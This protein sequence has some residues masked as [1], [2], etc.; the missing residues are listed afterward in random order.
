MLPLQ[1]HALE[2]LSLRT[3]PRTTAAATGAGTDDGPKAGQ[4]DLQVLLDG[5]RQG[6]EDA[7]SVSAPPVSHLPGST[8]LQ[9]LLLRLRLGSRDSRTA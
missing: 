7:G 5:E 3:S 1:L 9:E 8:E 6:L 2:R 4:Q